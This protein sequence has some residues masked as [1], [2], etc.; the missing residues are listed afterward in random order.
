MNKNILKILATIMA[1]IMLVV[2]FAVP[3]LA[4]ET[5]ESMYITAINVSVTAAS[6]TIFTKD[7]NGTD[8]VLQS[9]G[10]FRWVTYFT[11][12]PT[13]TSGVFEVVD[14]GANI[15]DPTTS[16]TIPEGGFIYTSHVDDSE[17]AKASG[18]YE[19]SSANTDTTKKLVAGNKISIVGVDLTAGTKT[20][21]AK[22]VIGATAVDTSTEVSE[23]VS[24]VVSDESETV[25]V[26]VSDEEDDDSSV[27]VDD[28]SVSEESDEEE[29]SNTLLY[30]GIGAA[31]IILIAVIAYAATRK[32]K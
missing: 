23:V 5:E 17:A 18:V 8:T 30:V 22:I 1:C 9:E 21:D 2:V 19:S 15:A 13:S 29:T 11:A 25:S 31:A 10:N 16:V 24:T 27:A 26:I 6:G 20:E 3:A 28:S 14:T 4:E 32:K 12:K 7:F